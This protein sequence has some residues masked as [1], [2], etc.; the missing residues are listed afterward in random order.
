LV[1]IL[2]TEESSEGEPAMK[3]SRCQSE[4]PPGSQACARCGA[5]LASQPPEP[6]PFTMTLQFSAKPPAPG[7]CI[8]GR[9]EVLEELGRGGMGT[10]YRVLDRKI[11]EEIALKL[12]KPEVATDVRIVERFKNELKL[13]RKIVHKNV[14]RVFDI[15][16]A[17][18][19]LFIT[20]EYVP[21]KN[22]KNL[23]REGRPVAEDKAVSIAGQVAE[24]LAEAHKLGVVHRDLKPQNI[25]LD[26]DGGVHIMDFGIARLM[27]RSEMT[28]AGTTIGTPEYMSPEQ[29]DGQPVDQRSDL[30]SLGVILYEMATGRVPFSGETPLSIAVKQKT[31]KPVDPRTLSPGLSPALGALIL[32]CLEKAPEARPQ[33]ARALLEGL[34]TL[35]QGTTNEAT[36]PVAG[37]ARDVAGAKAEAVKSIAVL[38]FKD[39]SPQQ[40]Q[41]Y[42]CEGLAEE[43]INA[44]TQVQDLRVAAR[45]SSFS[46]KDKA[47]D[48]R[49]IGR[50]LNVGALLEGSVQKAGDRLR[51]TVQLINVADGYHILSQ[52]FDR[53]MRDVFAVQDEIALA[54]V[55]KL[56]IELLAGEKEKMTKR[57]TRDEAAYNMYIKGRYFWNR[58]YQGDMIK[59]V[60]Y[61]EKA[62]S[63]DPGY[64]VPYVGIADV[65]NILGMWGYVH[66]K[67]AAARIRESL[68]KAL[69]LDRELSEAYSSLGF[70]E[71]THEHDFATGEE[72]MKR[73]IKLNPSNVYAHGWYAIFLGAFGRYRD[74]VAEAR[75]AVELEPLFSLMTAIEGLTMAV[76]GQIEHGRL[77][78][79]RAIEMDPSQPMAYL[80]LGFFYFLMPVDPLKGIEAL[81]RAVC[82]GL[83]FALGWLGLGHAMAGNEAQALEV[84][85]RLEKMENERYMPA[86]KKAVVF[87][88]PNLKFLRTLKKKYVSPMLKGVIYYGLN[89][90]AEAAREFEKS[91]EAGDF[92][93]ASLFGAGFADLPWKKEFLSRPECREIRKKLGLP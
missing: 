18:G 70:L 34:Q 8:A 69:D 51:I 39:M 43:L 45:T 81:Q 91:V 21:G 17:D 26:P 88:K 44:L 89:R 31:E 42:F 74:A 15:N 53:T 38:P 58:R 60:V 83:N 66:P 29:V 49:E 84:L 78:M 68:K 54:I 12:L 47:A 59:A 30:Y 55:D 72:H 46:F 67:V 71:F 32:R 22:L 2:I 10:V 75:R 1:I 3:C 92:F 82:F 64:A 24:G 65:F 85:A 37:T 35:A 90:Q 79:H 61:Y 33:T 93:L 28:E 52:R 13:A 16:E 76:S 48:I 41:D 6:P 73:S 27:G 62:I 57:H 25:M 77:L 4:N 23:V 63:R 5:T 19:A 80:F 20:M 56:K 14:C 7:T 50:L 11:N 86:F 87:L 36:P 9:Y 40:D